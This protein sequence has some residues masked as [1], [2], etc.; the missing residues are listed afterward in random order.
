MKLLYRILSLLLLLVAVP[1]RCE[2]SDYVITG[3]TVNVRATPDMNGKIVGH[4]HKD[5]HITVTAMYDSQWAENTLT[6]LF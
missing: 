1:V 2:T 6:H 4:L 3:N 5:D